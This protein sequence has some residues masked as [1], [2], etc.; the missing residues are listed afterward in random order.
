VRVFQ[1][2]L[3]AKD[4][5]PQLEA[6]M[7]WPYDREARANYRAVVDARNMTTVE[8]NAAQSVTRARERV[9]QDIRALQN[10]LLPLLPDDAE[11]ALTEAM[12]EAMAWGANEIGSRGKAEIERNFLTNGGL[13]RL[14]EAPSRDAI[15]HE[16]EAR[17]G[18]KYGRACGEILGYIV[19]MDQH[20]KDLS[21]S[22][23]LATRIMVEHAKFENRRIPDD[24]D[25]KKMWR[26]RGWGGVAPLWAAMLFWRAA[27]RARGVHWTLGDHVADVVASSHWLADFAVGFRLKLNR[28]HTPLLTEAEVIRINPKLPPLKP[29]IPPLPAQLLGWARSY[30]G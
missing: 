25:R 5:A 16:A 7:L 19:M 12:A 13:G 17:A 8:S 6:I 10:V 21:P 3:E 20:H 29:P 22:I 26:K 11:G 9:L 27:T 14:V 2:D 23:R 1:I 15:L 30:K 4:A 24:Y 18:G 28:S